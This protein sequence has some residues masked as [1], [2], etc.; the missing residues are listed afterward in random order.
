VRL[1]YH[2]FWDDF[3]DWYI[4]LVK[5]EISGE[6]DDPRKESAR[7]RIL[8]ILEY[9]LRILHP[10]MPYL[11][12]EIWQKLPG[13]GAHLHNSAYNGADASLMLT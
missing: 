8:S 3:C 7:T 1:I 4:K 6:S 11:T 5:D 12:E 10:F 9:S 2:F 13:A